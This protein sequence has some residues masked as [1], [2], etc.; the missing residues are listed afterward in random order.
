[1]GGE[2]L[3]RPL[4][5][6]TRHYPSSAVLVNSTA[7]TS[8]RGADLANTL[9]DL[10]RPDE[11]LAEFEKAKATWPSDP[12]L[13]VEWGHA[14]KRLNRLKEA[15]RHYKE[16][17]PLLGRAIK[18]EPWNDWAA[19]NL[20]LVLNRLNRSEGA[21]RWFLWAHRRFPEVVS[22]L[23]EL[24]EVLRQKARLA[25][26]EAIRQQLYAEAEEKLQHA[27]E[28]DPWNTW[29]WRVWGY[30]C[31]DFQNPGEALEKFEAALR[32]DP[33]DWSAWAGKGRALR[34]M[35]QYAK[36]TK[37]FEHALFFRPNDHNLLIDFGALLQ[38]CGRHEEA[39][40]K[41]ERGLEINPLNRW[42][43][44]LLAKSEKFR[45]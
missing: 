15:A 8:G 20:G 10:G 12:R 36:A 24:S 3:L 33:L 5:V 32:L 35:K 23:L 19:R 7:E 42:A 26:V 44:D 40:E 11:G 18:A 16:A 2:M 31:L 30:L 29:P 45:K 43:K 17:L 6:L 34:Q 13:F 4:V 37:A 41:L 14:L 1:M 9:I 21:L 39:I 22:I 28:V 25:K 27:M 38:D